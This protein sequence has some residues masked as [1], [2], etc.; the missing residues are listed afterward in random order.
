MSDLTRKTTGPKTPEGKAAVAQNRI[1]HCLTGARVLIPGENP[2][3]YNALLLA[4]MHEHSPHGPTETFLVEQ[5][6]H[7]Q[8]RLT[9]IAEME[10]EI[11]GAM[12]DLGDD[13]VTPAARATQHMIDTCGCD[14]AHRRLIRYETSIRR[15]WHQALTQLRV[16]QNLRK[17][18]AK[19]VENKPCDSITA[20]DPQP[21]DPP[22]TTPSLPGYNG[23]E[24]AKCDAPHSP[25]GLAPLPHS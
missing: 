12:A 18:E 13:A 3:F 1:I 24:K 15:A 2:E 6:A 4:L 7:N 8:H 5:L 17:R 21:P 19:A 23:E 9:R 10:T 16:M 11:F 22:L 20:P 14:E 25:S